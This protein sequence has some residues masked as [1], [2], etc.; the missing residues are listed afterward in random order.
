[1]TK[2]VIFDLDGTLVNLPIDYD[3]LFQEFRKIVKTSKIRP[4]TTTISRLDKKTRKKAFKVWERRELEAFENITTNKE[5]IEHYKGS[6]KKP[7]ALV[8]MQGRVLAQKVIEQLNLSFDTI[9]TREN[10]LSRAEQ[11][12]IA[13]K[14]L[15]VLTN[16]V[17]FIGNTDEDANAARK[18]SCHFLRVSE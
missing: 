16:E 10:S 17:L 4:L 11:L 2:A 18:I 1:M 7:K 13:A 15:G 14:E 9:V 6:L 12:E 5:G 8:T 3:V